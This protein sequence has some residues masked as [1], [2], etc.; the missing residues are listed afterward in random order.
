MTKCEYCGKDINVLEVNS[1][2]WSDKE[3]N[4]AIHDKCLEE[5]K[6]ENPEKINQTE[7]EKQI[8]KE[9]MKPIEK[10]IKTKILG[11]VLLIFTAL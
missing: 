1:Y 10:M 11:L 5:Y 4:R 2:T 6:K 3:N 8:Q 9:Y 7:G